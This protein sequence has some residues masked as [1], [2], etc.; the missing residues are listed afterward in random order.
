MPQLIMSAPYNNASGAIIW[1]C[2]PVHDIYINESNRIIG[3][4]TGRQIPPAIVKSQLQPSFVE[5]P[6]E[7]MAKSSIEEKPTS[8]EMVRE[9]HDIQTA[10]PTVEKPSLF[11]CLRT[12]Q[13]FLQQVR[14]RENRWTSHGSS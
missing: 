2:P 11:R 4:R 12:Y 1:Q 13:R 9:D 8:S 10:L 7:S 6:T 14:N 5:L 3:T